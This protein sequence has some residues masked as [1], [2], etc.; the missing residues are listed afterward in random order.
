MEKSW[1]ASK[2]RSE[3]TETT[4]DEIPAATVTAAIDKSTVA[5]YLALND[6]T[7]NTY[8]KVVDAVTSSA[9]ASRGWDVN[10]DQ[11]LNG[12]GRDDERQRKGQQGQRQEKGWQ[13]ERSGR[14]R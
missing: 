6:A 13:G 14:L 2:G 11:K 10:P 8:D 5:Q 3:P 1:T 9:R 4:A 12:R 7:L